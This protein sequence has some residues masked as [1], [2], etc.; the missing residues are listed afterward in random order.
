MTRKIRRL[1]RVAPLS[2]SARDMVFGGTYRP[3][4]CRACSLFET[5]LCT[6]QGCEVTAQQAIVDLNGGRP[7]ALPK[8]ANPRLPTEAERAAWHAR[9]Q[10]ASL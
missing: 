3:E 9:H 7:S 10:G 4:V 1:K 5:H 2:P 6:R 8:V